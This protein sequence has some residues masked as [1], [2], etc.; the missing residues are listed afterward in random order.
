MEMKNSDSVSRKDRTDIHIKGERK[1]AGEGR[2]GGRNDIST[3]ILWRWRM[4]ERGGREVRR[5]IF[6]CFAS[7]ISSRKAESDAPIF[8]RGELDRRESMEF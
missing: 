8:F 4:G 2:G 1:R 5:K 6:S 7:F 3:R